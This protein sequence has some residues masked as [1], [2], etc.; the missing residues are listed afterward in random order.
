MKRRS[1]R[2]SVKR[3][4]SGTLYE[5]TIENI[6]KENE[7]LG[8][9]DGVL[10][11]S[12]KRRASASHCNK[13]SSLISTTSGISIAVEQTEDDDTDDKSYKTITPPAKDKYLGFSY[14]GGISGFYKH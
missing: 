14:T 8:N 4:S 9:G 2:L 13:R 12:A 11:L 10:P 7:F 3:H 5:D 1:S 6:D